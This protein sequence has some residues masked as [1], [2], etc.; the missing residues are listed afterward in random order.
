M[1]PDIPVA[2]TLTRNIVPGAT[3]EVT[4]MLSVE[5]AELPRVTLVG[6]SVA[7]VPLIVVAVRITVPVNPV[8]VTVM[9]VVLEAPWKTLADDG[10]EVIVKPPTTAPTETGT[11][12][13]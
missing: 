12:T 11:V 7:V 4:V 13:E 5:V 9:V 2:V 3:L 6:L 8:L 10:L 1:L